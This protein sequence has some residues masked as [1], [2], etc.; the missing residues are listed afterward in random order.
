MLEGI[1]GILADDPRRSQVRIIRTGE[2][3]FRWIALLR[4]LKGVAP[5]PRDDSMT[6]CVFGVHEELEALQS[7]KN[8]H[9]L[10]SDAS[11]S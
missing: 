7:Q 9:I 2:C 6:G 5:L 10:L 11:S 3:R 1:G 4:M 8:S